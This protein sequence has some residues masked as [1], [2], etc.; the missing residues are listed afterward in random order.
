MDAGGPGGDE[1]WRHSTLGREL[2]VVASH[3]VHHFA[4][5]ALLLE[6]LSVPVAA[7]FGVAASTRRH[8]APAH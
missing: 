7:G 3:T 6:R 2:Q 8:E 1:E 5:I 4:L